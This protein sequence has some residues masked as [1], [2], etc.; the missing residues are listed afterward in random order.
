MVAD[1]SDPVELPVDFEDDATLDYDFL[2]FEGA[3]S[4]LEANPD[5]S[6]INTSATVMRTTKTEGAQFFAGTFLNLDAPIGFTD[7]LG[8]IEIDTWSPKADIPVRV[9]IE[10]IGNTA[11]IELDVNTTT[12]GEW[13]T[14]N[15]DFS[16][17]LDPNVEYVRIVVFFEFIEDLPG[18]GSTYFFDN[19]NVA[20]PLSA[21]DFAALNVS[22]YPNPSADRWTITSGV[23]TM[24]TVEVFDI[25]GQRVATQVPNSNTVAIDATALSTGMYIATIST[26]EGTQSIK[27]IKN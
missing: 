9:R 26:A 10:D 1:D 19:I 5:P 14:L 21:E 13:E 7:D 17:L 23:Q 2:G 25:L 12:V 4:A 22:A 15:Y 18:D 8:S 3:D 6:G 20:A 11:G 24:T 16:T 27:L